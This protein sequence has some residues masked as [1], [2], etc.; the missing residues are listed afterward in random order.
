MTAEGLLC[1][2]KLTCAPGGGAKKPAFFF[3]PYADICGVAVAEGAG[4]GTGLT[5]HLPLPLDCEAEWASDDT[6]AVSLHVPPGSDV[7]M[8]ALASFVQGQVA[9]TAASPTPPSPGATILHS[10]EEPSPVPAPTPVPPVEPPVPAD[11]P[12]TRLGRLSPTVAQVASPDVPLEQ[13]ASPTG[14]SP[15]DAQADSKEQ[16]TEPAPVRQHPAVQTRGMRR[17]DLPPVASMGVLALVRELAAL[18]YAR[19]PPSHPLSSEVDAPPPP[20]LG[21]HAMTR[22]MSMAVEEGSTH[23]VA[24]S[25][26]HRVPHLT[27]AVFATPSA[28]AASPCAVTAPTD[29]TGPS[30]TVSRVTW[31][32]A[33]GTLTTL[34][35]VG[36][37]VASPIPGFGTA[38]QPL[39]V[40]V[41]LL[42]QCPDVQE[43][44][45]EPQASRADAQALA[46]SPVELDSVLFCDAEGD[47]DPR[48]VLPAF[49]VAHDDEGADDDP[50]LHGP[51]PPAACRAQAVLD[52]LLPEGG[53]PAPLVPCRLHPR[54]PH[55]GLTPWASVDRVDALLGRLHQLTAASGGRAY[56]LQAPPPPFVLL[57]PD[58]AVDVGQWPVPRRT[59]DD[60]RR[61]LQE[62]QPGLASMSLARKTEEARMRRVTGAI[63]VKVRR[64]GQTYQYVQE[65][66][67]RVLSF[68]E[69]E[70][71]FMRDV[72]AQ[73]GGAQHF[74]EGPSVQTPHGED[75]WWL[76]P[77]GPEAFAVGVALAPAPTPVEA[78]DEAVRPP[79]V[80]S[81]PATAVAPALATP[82]RLPA[83]TSASPSPAPSGQAQACARP[84]SPSPACAS[85]GAGMSPAAAAAQAACDVITQRGLASSP[86][87]RD[88]LQAAVH[89]AVAAWLGRGGASTPLTPPPAARRA[90]RSAY[91]RR[92]R[93]VE[94]TPGRMGARLYL[95]ASKRQHTRPRVGGSPLR[96]EDAAPT[97]LLD[98]V[99]SSGPTSGDGTSPGTAVALSFA[100]VDASTST[101]ARTAT[102]PPTSAPTPQDAQALAVL[103]ALLAEDDDV[104]PSPLL[105]D[106]PAT[107][108]ANSASE[109]GSDLRSPPLAPRSHTPAPASNSRATQQQLVQ[110][111]VREG[112]LVLG[113]PAHARTTPAG[114]ALRTGPTPGGG[115][116]PL[117]DRFS[118][119]TL[120][121]S[122]ARPRASSGGS[123]G[124]PAVERLP[125][126][127]PVED[128][129]VL[130][131][132]RLTTA[133]AGGAGGEEGVAPPE[134]GRET[135][136][137]TCQPS[138]ARGPVWWSTP[139]SPRT[140]G[141]GALAVDRV[142]FPTPMGCDGSL[143]P[144]ATPHP[145]P[146]HT[147][148]GIFSAL[149]G[150]D[151]VVPPSPSL[152]TVQ[153]LI[154]SA[155][156]EQGPHPAPPSEEGGEHEQEDAGDCDPCQPR[157]I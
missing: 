62:L 90:V 71:L 76:H 72:V 66:S 140:P 56:P 27:H 148:T 121:S 60:H 95:S 15:G 20:D 79:A 89:A 10:A 117:A 99:G 45:L 77:Q 29:G 130:L 94:G 33:G 115:V 100:G 152:P 139:P 142:H 2:C 105:G 13:A 18:S 149:F 48:V 53:D 61:T 67:G 153:S 136:G 50:R 35:D 157:P 75:S 7:D 1:I 49:L 103:D 14:T 55:A 101:P 21:L 57:A 85:P 5:L 109:G 125:P 39:L 104:A 73:R 151:S 69:Y 129:G 37:P 80:P 74:L 65:G 59:T 150:T 113:T 114:R 126:V 81:S 11:T 108:S 42:R 156:H 131:S 26:P 23:A 122:P 92:P 19:T 91:Q 111:A 3:L 38:C 144:P 146:V 102:P 133:A 145:E 147:G 86:S 120:V 64:P 124:A 98:L 82:P 83:H 40:D 4:D 54:D 31:A 119:L 24:A 138:R 132:P 118:K 68:A 44:E 52:A 134:S 51:A 128:D 78:Q 17:A 32:G 9:Q 141:L 112:G 43:G 46:D 30:Q 135:S 22:A 155:L 106:I 154:N 36:V 123:V 41:A 47:T 34:Q 87:E 16:G 97:S 93:G 63:A 70:E 96:G 58:S 8:P 143:A 6:V 84:V 137:A 110:G 88:S 127:S 25:A 28:S 116:T 107:P 12:R